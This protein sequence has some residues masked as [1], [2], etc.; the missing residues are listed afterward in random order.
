MGTPRNILANP[1][2][3]PP[4]PPPFTAYIGIPC[5]ETPEIADLHGNVC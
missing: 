5:A 3:L 2:T 4:S 1:E